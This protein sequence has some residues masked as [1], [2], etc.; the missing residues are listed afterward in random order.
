MATKKETADTTTPTK[1][2]TGARAKLQ[3][4]SEELMN[5]PLSDLGEQVVMNMEQNKQQTTP[6]APAPK[7]KPFKKPN[8]DYFRLDLIVR[9]LAKGKMTSDIRVNYKDY[10]ETMAAAEGVSLTKY[11]HGMI[12]REMNSKAYKQKYEQIVKDRDTASK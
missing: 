10:L 1:K 6:P 4:A 7:T 5:K 9:G 8:S 3:K 12:E 11:I 2:P